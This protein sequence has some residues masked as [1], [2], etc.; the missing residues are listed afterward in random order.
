VI[1]AAKL[2]LVKSVPPEYPRQAREAATEGW[3]EL[4]FTV[5]ASGQVTDLSVRAGS[6]RGVFD[7]AAIAAVSQWRYKPVVAGAGPIT[8]RARIRI[9]F[10]LAH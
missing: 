10:T 3:V 7:N 1:D 2:V 8:Q 6:P 5:G 4:E 9:R